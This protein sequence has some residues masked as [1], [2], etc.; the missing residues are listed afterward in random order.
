VEAIGRG[1]HR[2]DR[3]GRP[4]QVLEETQAIGRGELERRVLQ[5]AGGLA[6]HRSQQPGGREIECPPGNLGATEG[7]GKT[8]DVAVGEIH[9][10]TLGQHEGLP[11]AGH[12]LVQE[13]VAGGRVG[14]VDGMAGQVAARSLVGQYAVLLGDQRRQVGFDPDQLGW[15]VEPVGAGVQAGGQV[16]D[17]VA[18]LRDG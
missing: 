5:H 14:Q 7:L 12:C 8:N 10:Q 13:R 18:A 6:V 2:F 11:G 17:T 15:Q 16:Q 4:A 1:H 9:Q 3:G